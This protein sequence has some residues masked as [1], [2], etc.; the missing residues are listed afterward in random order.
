MLAKNNVVVHSVHDA[1][2]RLLQEETH[3]R[4]QRSCGG[5]PADF[6]L[7]LQ[8]AKRAR[9]SSDKTCRKYNRPTDPFHQRGSL[10]VMLPAP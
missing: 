4:T 2:S 6:V 1:I 10:V 9:L 5:I 3:T 8:L 7:A